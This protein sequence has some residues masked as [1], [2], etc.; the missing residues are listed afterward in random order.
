[1]AQINPHFISNSLSAIQ[2]LIDSGNVDKAN[3]YMAKFSLLIRYVL[4]YSDKSVTSLS[5]EVKILELNI[6]LE[7]LRFTNSFTFRKNIAPELNLSEIFVRPLITQPFIENAIWHGLVP[8]KNEKQPE[9]ILGV[10]TIDQCIVIS[11]TDNGIGRDN[12]KIK[13]PIGNNSPRESMGTTLTKNRIENLNKLYKTRDAEI[14][15]IDLYDSAGRPAG[16]CVQIKLPIDLIEHL[17]KK[18][19]EYSYY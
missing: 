17:K 13:D 1:K 16:T 2:L 12:T 15:I 10:A 11:I 7:Q 4:K 6:E 8:L 19:H 5:D 3:L 9:I 18:Q 14:D